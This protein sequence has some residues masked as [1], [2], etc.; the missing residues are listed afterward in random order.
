MAGLVL[1]IGVG[2]IDL[3]TG[4]ELAFSLFYLFPIAL[5]TWFGGIKIGAATAI[6]SDVSRFAAD[7]IKGHPYSH[8]AMKQE[9]L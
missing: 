9:K 2:I 4:Y 6:T 8:P 5:V 1:V 3:L 7:A